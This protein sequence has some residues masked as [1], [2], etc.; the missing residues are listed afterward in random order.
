MLQ[1]EDLMNTRKIAEFIFLANS[2]SWSRLGLRGPRLVS[3]RSRDG[4]KELDLDEDPPPRDQWAMS[5]MSL[6]P[7]ASA[8]SRNL[9]NQWYESRL[10]HQQQWFWLHF[11]GLF[12]GDGVK[13]K[14][15][16]RIYTIGHKVTG[17]TR[18]AHRSSVRQM[19]TCIESI[20]F[21]ESPG[22]IKAI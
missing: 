3:G 6:A 17:L 18:E 13:S 11:L 15:C 4:H 7:T 1:R 5:A 20:P 16:F 10:R 8:I 21:D 2:S 14:L 9:R 19:S 12:R 22:S